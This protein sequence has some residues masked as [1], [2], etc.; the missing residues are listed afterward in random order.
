MS[1]SVDVQ[2]VR[3]NAFLGVYLGKKRVNLLPL[4]WWPP[5]ED[6][7]LQLLPFFL[8]QLLGQLQ[9]ETIGGE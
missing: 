5:S 3:S 6:Q 1:V 9:A 7:N 8:L 2:G 4:I